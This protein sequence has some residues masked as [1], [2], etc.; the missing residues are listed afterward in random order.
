LTGFLCALELD[1]H[2]E[3]ITSG[4]PISRTS[5]PCGDSVRSAH[6]RLDSIDITSG[7]PISRIL[8][9][10][11]IPVYTPK[12][13]IPALY[14]GGHLSKRPT[15]DSNEASSLLSLRGLAPG[16]GC[17]A[18]RITADAGG[19][20]HRLFTLTLTPK[21]ESHLFLWPDPAGRPA[22]GFPRHR[23]LWSAD[24]PRPRTEVRDRDRPA[25]LRHFHD[26][27][28]NGLRQLSARGEFV[29]NRTRKPDQ[30]FY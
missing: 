1:V 15:R 28:S 12:S 3:K 14:L 4:W 16:G 21:G 2:A 17:L 26:T 6:S 10:K 18:A 9:G 13:V 7:W 8:S 27:C 25:S 20:L 24:F 29:Y 23:A 22:P 30:P 19:L 11:G 5:S